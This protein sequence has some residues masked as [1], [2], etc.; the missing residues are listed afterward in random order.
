MMR[1]GGRLG[2]LLVLVFA[3]GMPAC[4]DD[5]IGGNTGGSSG[6][7]AG[8]AGGSS[9]AGGSGGSG[10]GGMCPIYQSFCNGHCISTNGD[11]NHCGGCDVTCTNGQAC[12][13]GRCSATCLP[14][15]TNCG[16]SCVDTQTSNEHCGGCNNPPCPLGTGCVFGTCQTSAGGSTGPAMCPIGGGGPPTN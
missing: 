16:G 4:G 10:D 13:A 3:S 5:T 14:G 9:G 7:G 8:G 11:P 15:S 2:L 12:S 1:S 6:A